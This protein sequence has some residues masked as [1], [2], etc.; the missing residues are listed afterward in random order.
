MNFIDAWNNTKVGQ[1]IRYIPEGIASMN[2]EIVKTQD[3]CNDIMELYCLTYSNRVFTKEIINHRLKSDR[4]E[5]IKTKR[6]IIIN[7]VIWQSDMI[8]GAVSP[9]SI[10]GNWQELLNK[11]KMK[12]ILEWEE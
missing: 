1:R 10:D 3:L 4:W 6:K 2:S 12:M 7:N 5:A 9:Y 8:S 11:P